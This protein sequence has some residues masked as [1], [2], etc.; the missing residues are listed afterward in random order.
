MTTL[1]DLETWP[2]GETR[3]GLRYDGHSS[4]GGIDLLYFTELSDVAS[5][6]A[7]FCLKAQDATPQGIAQRRIEKAREF[8]ASKSSPVQMEPATVCWN[9]EP[10]V[11][12]GN[13]A[14]AAGTISTG[15]VLA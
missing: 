2:V 11:S 1:T 7:T 13:S 8:A 4:L 3:D 10:Q 9:A 14:E 5:H 6:G 15:E 12:R